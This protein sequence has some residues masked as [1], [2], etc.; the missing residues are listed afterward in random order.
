MSYLNGRVELVTLLLFYTLCRQKSVTCRPSCPG[1]TVLSFL[2]STR[3]GGRN[4]CRIERPVS[5][6]AEGA[7]NHYNGSTP[8]LVSNPSGFVDL[9]RLTSSPLLSWCVCRGRG[10][11]LGDVCALLRSPPS[12]W[13]A[14]CDLG[15]YGAYTMSGPLRTWG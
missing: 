10:R 3:A 4:E 7:P 11:L 5:R 2:Y 1:T 12:F 14:S 15:S 13:W 9:K 8:G 6:L